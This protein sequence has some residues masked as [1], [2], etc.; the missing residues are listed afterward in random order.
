[1]VICCNLLFVPTSCL[2]MRLQIHRVGLPM[3]ERDNFG[4]IENS[5]V[6]SPPPPLSSL[7]RA[8]WNGFICI[9]WIQP[10]NRG[11]ARRRNGRETEAGKGSPELCNLEPKLG[12]GPIIWKM[13][14]KLLRRGSQGTN[15]RV[16]HST[17]G[18]DCRESKLGE[19]EI[20]PFVRGKSA[21]RHGMRLKIPVE[22]NLFTPVC[23][24]GD[25]GIRFSCGGNERGN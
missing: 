13:S 19:S 8:V 20:D 25:W 16:E 21:N 9:Q 15:K 23:I 14:S 7:Q 10:E 18:W 1:M 4:A 5:K 24:R 6:V 3:R 17:K 22:K 11:A 12:T 2:F